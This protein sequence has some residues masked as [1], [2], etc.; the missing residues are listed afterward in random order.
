VT[1]KVAERATPDLGPEEWASFVVALC[2]WFGGG[3]GDDA[4]LAWESNGPGFQF[5][6]RVMELGYRNLFYRKN[7]QMVGAA[8]G[9]IPGWYST[10]DN[11]RVLLGGYQLDLRQGKFV[12]RSRL[13]LEECL[14]YVY[15]NEKIVHTGAMVTEDPT[16]AKS[17]HGDR[18]I[19]DALVAKLVRERAVVVKAATEA[20][21]PEGS[22]MAR[23]K[24]RDARDRDPAYW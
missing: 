11:K 3:D 22:F 5:G 2:R 18:V 15:H 20:E 9:A 17:N 13:G 16:G 24:A 12:N 10:N 23:R 7:E 14:E 6:K 1:K 8:E 4:V 21:V 19:A